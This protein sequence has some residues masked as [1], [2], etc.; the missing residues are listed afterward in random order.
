MLEFPH[1]P[2]AKDR[3]L[4]DTQN[5]IEVS[6]LEEDSFVKEPQKTPEIWQPTPQALYSSETSTRPVDDL[7][8]QANLLQSGSRSPPR[9]V[10]CVDD[11]RSHYSPPRPINS[12][13]NNLLTGLVGSSAKSADLDV[14]NVPPD[15]PDT[16]KRKMCSSSSE[17]HRHKRQRGRHKYR[18]CQSLESDINPRGQL[19]ENS[20]DDVNIGVLGLK[21]SR[22]G[23]D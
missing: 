20:N 19:F 9:D 21:H 23:L 22:Q 12:L 6:D 5:T 16:P 17:L 8:R 3:E 18:S 7:E 15:R 2:E 14:R 1:T 10:R 11:R 13:C 4:L